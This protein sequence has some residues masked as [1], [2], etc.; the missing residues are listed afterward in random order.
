MLNALRMIARSHVVERPV[1]TAMTVLGIALGVAVSVA[2]RTANVEV[3]KS[4]E[5]A[6]LT[7]AGRATLQVSGGE[8]G[9]DERVI[10]MLR[11]QPGVVSASPVVQ[12]HAQVAAGPHRGKPLVVMGLDLLEAA[13]HR[14]FRLKTGAGAEPTL[15]PLLEPNAVF[16]GTRLAAEWSLSEGSPLDLLI[17]TSTYRLVVRGVVE[18]STGVRTAW[19]HLAVMDI[20]AAQSLFGSAGKLD[21]I[22]LVTDPARPVE[23]IAGAIAPLLPPPL[24]IQRPAHRNEQVERM[25]RA[26][27]L[28]LATL[29]GVGLLVGLLLVYNT[30][31]YS[32]VR[33]R[34][35]I[36]I[37]RALGLSRP[38]IA[39]LFVGEAAVMGLIGGVGGSIFGVLLARQLVS[40]LSRTVS[41]L[42]APVSVAA[43]GL[44]LLTPALLSEGG[45]F[46]L[47]VA[48]L[49]A[50]APSVDASRTAPARALA[51][52]EYEDTQAFRARPLAWVGGGCLVLAGLLA[53]P[54]PVGGLP[55]F[56][57][58]SAFCLLLSLSCFAPLLVYGVGTVM[59]GRGR[60]GALGLIAAEQI[61]RAPGRNAITASALMI[62][63]AIMIG[64]G[65]M[66]Q[67]FRQT[68]DEWIDQT[69]MADLVVAAPGWLTGEENGMQAKR[70][71]LA[72]M[73]RAA[74]VPGVAAVDTYRD[75]T[76]ELG[77]RPV[78]LVS[79][80]L[81]VHAERSRYL[82][83][84][85]NSHALLS[86]T[87]TARG[88]VISEVLAGRLGLREGSLLTLPTPSGERSFPVI[89]VFYDYATD[90]GKLVMDRSL[91]R[92]LWNDD[93][94]TV[95]AVYVARDADAGIV[96]QRLAD[97][98]GQV[99]QVV[100]ITNAEIKREI[101]AIF[102]RT[103][104]VT[105][106]LEFIAVVIALLGIVNTLLT[107]VLERQRE[108]ATLRAVGASAAQI[109]G[110]VLWEGLYLGLLGACLGVAGGLALS[111]LLIHVINKQSFGW[112]IHFQFP[113]WL[114]VEGVALALGAALI[115]SYAPALWAARQPVVEGLRYE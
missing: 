59:T 20:A 47:A 21:R 43:D 33:H 71:P 45:L 108:M 114:V 54:G 38:G 44:S 112:T 60:V 72:W 105:Y 16:V 29:S 100:V 61:A 1:R 56:G 89:G 97:T 48:M 22:D 104:T 37:L 53:W 24:T 84:N 76:V 39:A 7:V 98:M 95:I 83:L 74:A 110:L 10:A 19:E 3:L 99:G 2:I 31:A 35:E 75:L 64:V 51:P 77:G 70:M 23:E 86:R 9:L 88:V 12:Q 8:L 68:V 40:S 102:D 6:V 13:D 107:S 27:Q 79:R 34:R 96:R 55:L 58:A 62:G 111:F 42:Y 49:G 82:F 101:L 80:D 52:G 67:S 41:D 87:V 57:Y 14:N 28:N 63:I 17:G 32:V 106:S 50:L 103:F 18:S 36:G 92:T 66:I 115:A 109:R 25:V 69:V 78:S 73:S 4:F 113:A 65:I 90:G 81:R 15:D 30:I 5:E 91:Y 94:T 85:G 11:N 26:F 93:T 46:G